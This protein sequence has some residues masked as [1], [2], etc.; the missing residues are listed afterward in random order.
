MKV[1]RIVVALALGTAA[2]ADDAAP[3]AAPP[4]SAPLVCEAGSTPVD[5][6]CVPAGFEE[7]PDGVGK[8]G[9]PCSEAAGTCAPG[10]VAF[11]GQTTCTAVGPGEC[12]SGFARDPSGFGCS[13]ILPAAACTGATTRVSGVLRRRPLRWDGG[14]RQYKVC[15]PTGHAAQTGRLSHRGRRSLRRYRAPSSL[16]RHQSGRLPPQLLPRRRASCGRSAPTHP[17]S[18]VTA[19]VRSPCCQSADE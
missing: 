13:P 5:D 3:G 2:C 10:T 14:F 17:L 18:D 8:D 11:F 6:R 19:P 9:A 4:P 16:R 15:A 1:G 12:P 7:C